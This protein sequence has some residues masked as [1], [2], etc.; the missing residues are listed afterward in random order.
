MQISWHIKFEKI[1]F[2]IYIYSVL[3]ITFVDFANY[4][5]YQLLYYFKNCVKV[6]TN[7]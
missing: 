7:M 2:D 3:S 1:K 5:I 4:L 6:K